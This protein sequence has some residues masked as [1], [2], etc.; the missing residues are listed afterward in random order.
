[1]DVYFSAFVARKEFRMEY[2]LRRADREYRWVLDQ[3]RPRYAPSGAF[4]GYIGSCID[5]T[6]FKETQEAQRRFNNELE[7]RVQER[8]AELT[9]SNAELEE[10]ASVVSHDLQEPLRVISSYVRLLERRY[11]AQLDRD[12]DDFISFAVD[13]A[14][15]MQELVQ[16]LLA[17]ARI[18]TGDPPLSL[19][20]SG[21]ALGTALHD[22][23]QVVGETGA[24]IVTEPLPIVWA[25]RR[26]L[27]Q[28]FQNLME[29]ALKFRGESP[30]EVHVQAER[31]AREWLFRVR[32]NGIGIDPRHRE[33]IFRIFE[34]L[35]GRGEYPGTGIGLSVCKKIVERAGGRIWVE[36]EPGRGANFYFT[37]PAR[38]GGPPA[39]SD[40]GA[41]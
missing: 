24:R 17:Y 23:R 18:G 36:S 8:T 41:S 21:E 11:K 2:R 26:Q 33:R 20:D 15:R 6:E 3:G 7:R 28:L 35:H 25:D 37:L 13:G 32:D 10:F 38:Q 4:A 1:M 19:V 40:R 22:L 31:L 27:T 16:A 34:R 29:N 5:V 14:E 12:A 39:D 30:P 9:R